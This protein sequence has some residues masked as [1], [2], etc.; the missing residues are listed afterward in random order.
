MKRFWLA[1]VLVVIISPAVLGETDNLL[2]VS[3]RPYGTLPLGS[4]AD[5]F[6]FGG[7]IEASAAFFPAIFRVVGFGLGSNLKMLP[8]ESSDGLWM[9]TGFGGVTVRVPLGDRFAVLGHGSAG[10]YYW[11]GISW[12]TG[13]TNGGGFVV[14]GGVVGTFR[15]VG[16]FSLGLGVSYDYYAKLYNGIGFD[17]AVRFDFPIEAR[18]RPLRK[19]TPEKVKPEPLEEKEK[20][21]TEEKAEEG[22]GVEL[23]DIQLATLFPVM[24]KYYDD[25]PVGTVVVKNFESEAAENIRL[26]FYVERYM[27]NPMDLGGGFDLGPGEK[28]E[29]ALYGLFT[30]DLMQITEGTKASAKITLSYSLGGEEQT[31]EYT[32]VLKF[33][34][35][36]ALTWDDDR[37]IASFVTAKDP[38]ILTFA[39]NVMTWIQEVQ[40]PQVDEH[41]Q[42]GM[43][44]FEALSSYGIRYEIDPTT[45]FAELSENETA[46]DFLQFPRQTLQYTNGDCDDLS[47]LYTSLLEAVGVETAVITI[48]GHI[49]TAF[50]LKADPEEARRAFSRPDNLVF[51]EKKA[52]VPVE[53]TMCQDTF[54]K[55]W[56]EGAKEWRENNSRDQANLY[57]TRTS[58]RTYQAVGFKEGASGIRLPERSAVISAFEKS[59]TRHIEREIYPQVAKIQGKMAESRS[60]YK[61]ENKLAVLY[62]RHGLYGRA[63]ETLEEITARREYAPAL[64]NQGNIYFLRDEYESALS[65]Y[66]R[67]LDQHEGNRTAL[68]GVARCHHELENYGFVGKTYE[69][70]QN[71]APDL[72]MRF[73]YLDLRGE[74]AS[75]ASDAA[76]LQEI[77]VWE[78]EE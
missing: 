71:V 58:W 68:L 67:V 6:K 76:G 48:P 33:H 43:A 49:Y 23:K 3:T 10:Y 62:A 66:Q 78:E 53:I 56:K 30:E 46:V 41:L 38:E 37:K 73:A 14:K 25:N 24:Y 59:L 21:K 29:V 45:P 44:V 1:L 50:A 63:L 61:Y 51:R 28:R 64:I 55:A 8:L 5:L 15:L 35:R 18:K 52:W 47:A 34:N 32:P 13:G 20:P 27:D 57:P 26:K 17:L 42:K 12:D 70:L 7:G 69:K 16:P 4:S 60:P 54:E 40:N 19:K 65:Y 2:S 72:A 31:E 74:E 22:E 39:K 77:V 36:N 75:R 11:N 9:I